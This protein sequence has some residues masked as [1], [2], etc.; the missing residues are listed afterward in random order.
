MLRLATVLN[1]SK[2]RAFVACT[3]AVLLSVVGAGSVSADESVPTQ[4]SST[5]VHEQFDVES[6]IYWSPIDE[7]TIQ[8]SSPD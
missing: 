2:R 8:V 6:G 5:T 4:S 7:Q 1:M 3:A